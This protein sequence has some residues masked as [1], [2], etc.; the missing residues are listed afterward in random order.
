MKQIKLSLKK[1][2]KFQSEVT[3][4]KIERN[5]LKMCTFF[6][7][8][9][10]QGKTR[11]Q[12]PLHA[13]ARLRKTTHTLASPHKTSQALA[14]PRKPSHTLA[15]LRTPSHAFAQPCTPSQALART[16]MP[17]ALL[18]TKF[19]TTLPTQKNLSVCFTLTRNLKN[20]SLGRLNSYNLA[21]TQLCDDKTF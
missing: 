10:G 6:Q 7:E 14:C 13:H 15:S 8:S 17:S 11:P 9:E 5:L 19:K 16:H 20:L 18:Y 12:M 4:T 1:N 3:Q 21:I 2:K